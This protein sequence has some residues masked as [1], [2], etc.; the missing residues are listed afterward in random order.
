MEKA[1]KVQELAQKGEN[2]LPLASFLHCPTPAFGR[3]RCK[4]QHA[5]FG[6]ACYSTRSGVLRHSLVPPLVTSW[7]CRNLWIHLPVPGRII[8]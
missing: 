2:I 8:I 1:P 5:A 4:T 7:S 6:S 3:A